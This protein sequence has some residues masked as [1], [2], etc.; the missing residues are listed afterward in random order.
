[1]PVAPQ[2]PVSIIIPVFNDAELLRRCLD[3]LAHQTYPADCYEVIVVDNGSDEPITDY[4]GGPVRTILAHE[5]RPGSYAARN[6]GLSLAKG[7]IIGF[8]DA[9]C[10]PSSDWIENGVKAVMQMQGCGLVGGSIEIFFRDSHRPTAVE[11]YDRV[12]GFPQEHYI[13]H[14][15]FAPTANLFMHRQVIDVVGPFNDRLKSG[16]DAEWGS[17]ARA[18]GYELAYASNV[19]VRHPARRSL[20]ELCRKAR[21]V[22]GGHH[23]LNQSTNAIVASFSGIAGSCRILPGAFARVWFDDHIHGIGARG[24]VAAIVLLLFVVRNGERLRLLLGGEPLRK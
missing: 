24:K 3:A 2:P 18:Y 12:F 6:T 21:R 10:I 17:R 8:T 22:I 5:Q 20:G 16:G 4:A 11:L 7:D 23:G 1:M 14:A 9:D 13:K 15:G 19:V